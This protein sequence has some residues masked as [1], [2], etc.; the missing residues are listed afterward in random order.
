MQYIPGTAFSESAVEAVCPCSIKTGAGGAKKERPDNIGEI[1]DHWSL[2][3]LKIDRSECAEDPSRPDGAPC[4]RAP[5]LEAITKFVESV[6]KSSD[7]PALNATPLLPTAK[8]E[9]AKA[10][11]KAAAVLDCG[12]ESC[13]LSHPKFTQF[14][15]K[16]LGLAAS[17]I[18]AE[19]E[20]RF[21]TAGP[22]NSLALLNN[23]NIDETLERWARVYPE[24]FAYPFAMMDFE[25]TGEPLAALDIGDIFD[26]KVSQKMGPGFTSVK[27]PASCAGCVLNTDISSGAGKHWVAV[28]IDARSKGA[29]TVEYFNSAGRPPPKPVVVWMEKTRARLIEYRKQHPDLGTSPVNTVAVTSIS[30]QDGQTECGLYACFYIRKRLEGTP[31]SFFEKDLIPDA[32]MTQFRQ[33]IFRDKS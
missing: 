1:T 32:V 33:F 13:V 12:S 8:T 9:G 18:E 3:D 24:F 11:V 20:R 6:S 27:R 7:T 23:Y 28:F 26:G 14:A 5:I 19:K 10:V 30:H 25:K 2:S 4:S 22:R 17:T 29:W 21:K 15:E 16:K 31:F